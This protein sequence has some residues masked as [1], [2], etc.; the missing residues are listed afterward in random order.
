MA[1]ALTGTNVQL[2]GLRSAQVAAATLGAVASLSSTPF[3]A[4]TASSSQSVLAS[5][6]T[7]KTNKQ[8]IGQLAKDVAQ[9]L[10]GIVA[11]EVGRDKDSMVEPELLHEIGKFAETMSKFQLWLD[12]YQRTSKLR[13]L[14][15]QSEESVQLQACKK[16]VQQAL[17]IFKKYAELAVSTNVESMIRDAQARHD[18][19][20]E[21]M[22]SDSD[23]SYSAPF[24][25]SY[26][27]GSTGS[28]SLL[29][30]V[31]QL[32]NG[33]EREL[34]QLIHLLL[35]QAARVAILGPGGMGKTSLAVATLHDE[36]IVKKYPNRHFIPCD[37]AFT[38]SHLTTIIGINLGLEP[39]FRTRQG[40]IRHL[41]EKSS[42]LLVL[43]NFETPWE[44]QENRPGVEDFVSALSDI[45]HVALVM[46]MRGTERPSKTLWTR[47]FMPPLEPLSDVAARQTFLDIVDE[48]DEP[49]IVDDLL[50]LT[51]NVPLAVNLVA[52]VAA[53][54]GS[55]KTLERFKVER[56]ATLIDGNDKRSNIE[57]SIRISLSSPRIK[58]SPHAQE[59]LS[60]VSLL[61]DGVFDVDLLQSRL[62][63]PDVLSHKIILI[64]TSLAYADPSGRLRVLAPIREY[65][66][67]AHPPMPLTLRRLRLHFH[68][69]SE[70][71][72]AFIHRRSLMTDLY[73][74]LSLNMGNMH[75]LLIRGLDDDPVDL[76]ITAQ[77][78]LRLNYFSRLMSRGISPLFSRI[79]AILPSLDDDFIA[80]Q[81]H[82]AV[83][84]SWQFIKIADPDNLIETAI[85]LLPR[86]E[87]PRLEAA[88]Y[89][90][91]GEYYLDCAHDSKKA[92][93]FFQRALVLGIKSDEM[94]PQARAIGGLAL[95]EWFQGNHKE[96][97]RLA[98]EQQRLGYLMDNT[99]AE[100]SGSRL[101]A[102]ALTAIGDFRESARALTEGRAAIIRTHMLN[103]Q[104]DSMFMNVEAEMHLVKTEYQEAR[105]LYAKI[106]RQSS[107]VF[108]PQTYA[109]AVI[110]LAF[111]DIEIGVHPDLILAH[112]KTAH[113]PL[114]RSNDLR[115]T[116]IV[117]L[118]EG[119]LSLREGNK[120]HARQ[121]L[122]RL[123]GEFR[124]D[125]E[126]CTFMCLTRLADPTNRL[127]DLADA[128][129]WATVFFAFA[130]RKSNR[131]AIH[132]ALR[133]L[134]EVAI[135][136]G[137]RTEGFNLLQLALEGFTA[138]DVHHSRAQ[139]LGSLARLELR[140]GNRMKAEELWRTARPLFERCHQLDQVERIN[141][142]L[143]KLVLSDG[144]RDRV[145]ALA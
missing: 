94:V 119:C 92:R 50:A 113:E 139:C 69:L 136:G 72:D 88:L 90:A 141:T 27:A 84:L 83:L 59:L 116:Q 99:I 124:A 107:A 34:R 39:A 30:P 110:G 31:P 16:G 28:L 22:G 47:P 109:Y 21:L 2:V 9:I 82:I 102:M 3:L 118:C 144:G 138:M 100:I 78:I 37:S 62:P 63:I 61:P 122:T 46:T 81:Y 52:R 11:L 143:S 86:L 17:N 128:V 87:R 54:E 67:V 80:L 18:Q 6:Q 135:W 56:T 35:T 64:R 68:I 93:L 55:A 108:S 75:Q 40:I 7:L 53:V 14:F 48:Q 104:Y 60:L 73:L 32:F 76:K 10:S 130:Q 103:S 85:S 25:L 106:E 111:V 70:L 79:P 132:Q 33:R 45:P 112:I 12:A 96:C 5:L 1:S 129:R 44:P 13:R 41:T 95:L 127:H 51:D 120:L 57:T 71:W 4:T 23:S 91:A 142:S 20:I 97:I 15:R 101:R 42:S 121:T 131:L 74:R 29:P 140:M 38:V 77:T 49:G 19:L 137:D 98:R 105:E 89:N 134:A 145:V 125:D 115:G 66:Q 133:C 8:E 26:S 117:D 114:H 123:F 36:D 126:E 43:D 65:I 58:S 24:S